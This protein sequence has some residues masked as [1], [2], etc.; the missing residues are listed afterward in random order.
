MTIRVLVH[1]SQA[2]VR[3]AL[4]ALLSVRHDIDV[5][6]AVDQ[7]VDAAELAARLCP[8]VA[9]LEQSEPP[10][11]LLRAVVARSPGTRVLVRGTDAGGA[12]V[13][14]AVRA[15]ASGYLPREAGA[16]QLVA[17]IRAVASGGAYLTP[18][19]TR[20][21]LDDFVATIPAQRSERLVELTDQE[22]EVLRL[23][24]KGHSNAELGARLYLSE[25]TVK[26]H[27]SHVFRKLGVRDRVQAVVAAY[28][29][30]LVAP[31]VTREE[32]VTR[33][34]RLSLVAGTGG[35]GR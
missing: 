8:H 29:T 17:A 23:L 18:A 15:G 9:L 12:A 34:P 20:Q 4:E 25:S 33:R 22:V 30:R 31:G 14:D 27:L 3:E 24:A 16:A 6:G 28:E 32:R 26:T 11:R 13:Y 35:G 2:L 7:T 5:V 1:E 21:L 10:F 19:L